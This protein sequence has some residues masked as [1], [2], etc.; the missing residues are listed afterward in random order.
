MVIESRQ[1]HIII[2]NCRDS[3]SIMQASLLIII[4]SLT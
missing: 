4:I 1:L 2:C 3:I